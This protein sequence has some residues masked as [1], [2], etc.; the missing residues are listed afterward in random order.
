MPDTPDTMATALVPSTLARYSLPSTG[1]LQ[2]RWGPSASADSSRDTAILRGWLSP[3]TS[4]STFPPGF[5]FPPSTVSVEKMAPAATSVQ[6]R[7]RSLL[8]TARPV[9]SPPWPSPPS[10]LFEETKNT[11]LP[12]PSVLARWIAPAPLF[13]ASSPVAKN[14]YAGVEVG[15]WVGACE[16]ACEGYCEG[17]GEG[18]E[19]G[20][21]VGA[22]VASAP[23]GSSEGLGEGSAVGASVGSSLGAIESAAVEA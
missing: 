7:R 14:R 1:S 22:R 11:W 20:S 10:P 2:K 17:T 3:V 4:V 8:C 18:K 19:V 5:T 13:W 15:F 6:N 16:G 12:V 9:G 23:V 21:S